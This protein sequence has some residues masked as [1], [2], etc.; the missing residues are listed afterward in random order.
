MSF[1]DA[2][3]GPQRIR[4]HSAE[5]VLSIQL[6]RRE[7]HERGGERRL[8]RQ[9]RAYLRT[10]HNKASGPHDVTIKDAESKQSKQDP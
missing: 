2:K 5:P 7:Q 3:S 9:T 1:I 8:A 10:M 6:Q 4:L